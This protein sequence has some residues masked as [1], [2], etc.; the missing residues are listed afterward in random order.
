[1]S[2]KID[3]TLRR[4]VKILFLILTLLS[5]FVYFLSLPIGLNLLLLTN[6]GLEVSDSAIDKIPV[7]FFVFLS[8]NIPVNISVG[9]FFIILIIFYSI[10]FAIAWTLRVSLHSIMLEGFSKPMKNALNNFLLTMPMISSTLMV[11]IIAIQSLQESYGIETG[12]ISFSNPFEGLFQLTYSPILEEVAYRISPLGFILLII[13]LIRFSRKG[14][15]PSLTTCVLCFL[16]PDKAKK[17]AN[18][19]TMHD[20]GLLRGISLPEWTTLLLTCSIFGLNHYLPGGGWGLGKI[21]SAFLAGFVFGLAYLYYGIH[22]PILLHWSF[23]YYMHAYDLF[24]ETYPGISE[25]FPI[26][27][28]YLVATLGAFGLLTVLSTFF[29]RFLTKTIGVK[30][31]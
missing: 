26:V 29:N 23:N 13:I 5:I 15:L 25:Y 1:M 11:I 19:D 20:S 22:A 21:S 7:Y 9:T 16:Y 4:S 12:S 31:L 17:D 24:S 3:E 6:E 14:Y 18:M 2:N 8:F 30:E 27:I 28:I 10:C